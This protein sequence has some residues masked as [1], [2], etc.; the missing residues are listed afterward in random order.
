[1]LLL[2]TVVALSAAVATS[3]VSRMA[4]HYAGFPAT[5]T[6]T[7]TVTCTAHKGGSAHVRQSYWWYGRTPA[8]GAASPVTSTACSAQPSLA[9]Q[10][11]ACAS[12]AAPSAQQHPARGRAARIPLPRGTL[13]L[14]SRAVFPRGRRGLARARRGPVIKTAFASRSA[15]EAVRATAPVGREDGAATR[16]RWLGRGMLSRGA[17]R[18]VVSGA[19]LARGRRP[20]AEL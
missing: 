9:T 18:S 15:L 20:A 13:S 7:S 4:T 1:M 2:L 6:A 16:E 8:C 11:A 10:A 5:S 17:V 3:I 12:S 19:L 14:L